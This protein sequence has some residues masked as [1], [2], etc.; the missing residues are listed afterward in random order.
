M[1]MKMKKGTPIKKT[2]ST[3]EKTESPKTTTFQ[4]R[5]PTQLYKTVSDHADTEM[6]TTAKQ[7]ILILSQYYQGKK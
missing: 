1:K 6:R 4:I 2:E 5:I 7:I 3:I